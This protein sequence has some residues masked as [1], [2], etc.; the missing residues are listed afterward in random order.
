[1]KVTFESAGDA[2]KVVKRMVFLAYEACGGSTGMGFLQARTSANEEQVWKAAY[3]CTD[4]SGGRKLQGLKDSEVYCDYVMGR[5]KWGCKWTQ[6]TI[7]IR[8]QKFQHDYQ[9][10]SHVYKDNG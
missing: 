7:E 5:M 8:D 10:F 4:Y 1:M 6:T 9:A 3:N 2:E